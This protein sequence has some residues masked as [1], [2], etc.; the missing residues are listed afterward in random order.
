MSPPEVGQRGPSAP[1]DE[2]Y[3]VISELT[4]DYL[5]VLR[6][7][8]DGEVEREWSNDA[9]AQVTG[10]AAEELDAPGAWQRLIHP[11]DLP[12]AFDHVVRL[13]AG[14]R[15]QAE[16]RIIARSGER[17]WLRDTGQPVR[18][19]PDGPVVRIYGAAQD[20][21]AHKRGEERLRFLAEA[22]VVLDSSLD[23]A[24]TLERVARLAVP[25][26]A[27]WCQVD[28]FDAEDRFRTVAT[29]H[30]DP[31]KERLA[32][33]LRRRYPPD[34]HHP[35]S[36]WAV[37]RS[38]QPVLVSAAGELHAT[39]AR[40]PEHA[41]LL[42]LMATRSFL[43]L[44]LR[45]SDRILGVISFGSQTPNAFGAEDLPFFGDLA[46]RA[47]LAVD[48]ARLYS[49]LQE[50]ER[51]YH[52]L[53][54]AAADALLIADAEGRYVEANAAAEQ[55]LGHSRAELLEM[56]VADVVV[57]G[58]DWTEAEFTRFR[59]DG[60]W[61]GEL[62]LRRKDGS[63]VPVEARA[64][65]I[66]TAAG[67]LNVSALRDISQRRAIEESQREFV[68]LI[69]HELRNPLASLRGYAQLLARRKT[70][71]E[72]AVEVIV[73]QVDRLNRL[74]GDLVD[75]SRLERG[76]LELNCRPVD[77]TAV[78]RDAA[79]SARGY[80]EGH[81]IR[82][83]APAAM[84]FGDWDHHRIGQVLQNLLSNALKYSPPGEVVLRLEDRGDAARASVIDHGP[85][86]SS[87]EVPRLFQR[88]YRAADAAESDAAGLGLGLYICR[89]LV[90]SHGGRIWVEPTP[91]GG[92]TF[93]FELPY[94]GA[95][96][97]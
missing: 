55:L 11:D 28:V 45:A 73:Q 50:A 64:T 33:E 38:G 34:P 60:R 19:R 89:G 17:R 20:V 39:Q 31:E 97:D 5:Y 83:E 96:S 88:F 26:L 77:L 80:A 61:Q 57:A 29:A 30:V 23:F 41:R 3:R 24:A 68:A 22:S 62:D 18:E 51:R 2:L 90:E 10:Y 46:R 52:G 8:P 1:S 40:D 49:S 70:Y 9:F 76:R 71:S 35:Q 84:P 58:G 21:T 94:R 78:A 95:Q 37:Y 47:A 93:A 63:V 44:P 86:I 4:S 82:L 48:N 15:H 92:A 43:R 14:E 27:D 72:A 65:V 69:G 53:F 56:R 74:I 85:G 13:Q 25:L 87:R 81:T 42:E 12:H 36:I 54:E 6:V 66:E 79:A 7:R 16:Y 91:G 67:Q 32:Q 59:V 75:A